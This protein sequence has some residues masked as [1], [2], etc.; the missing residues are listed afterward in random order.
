MSW[1]QA[2]ATRASDN[3]SCLAAHLA[4]RATDR[5]C[6]Q[7]RGSEVAN[8]ASASSIAPL[9]SITTSTLPTG[10]LSADVDFSG[11]GDPR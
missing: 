9:T 10:A 3:D 1:S 8:L 2:A 7:R 6:R 11:S 4:R 5:T